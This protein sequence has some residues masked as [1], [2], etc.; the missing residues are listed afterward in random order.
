MSAQV[1]Y[2]LC[3]WKHD[4]SGQ[5]MDYTLPLPVSSDDVLISAPVVA[6]DDEDAAL[7][8]DS[9]TISNVTFAIVGDVWMVTFWLTGG[10]AG[11]IYKLRCRWTLSDGR[12]SDRTVRLVC[13]NT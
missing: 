11:T 3:T 2:P 12:G 9:L 1:L 5:P 13:A 8:G 7:V 6:V 10:T 4:P